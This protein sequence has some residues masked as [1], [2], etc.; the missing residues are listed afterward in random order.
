MLE[1]LNQNSG[2]LM[3]VFT[4]V[5]TLSTVVYAMLTGKLVSETRLMRRAHTEPR[6]EVVVKPR[7][8][9]VNLVSLH[10]RN[11]GLGP[12]YDIS[13][14]F[15]ADSGAAGAEKLIRDFTE[16]AFL[17]QG[18][19]YLG[20]GQ[21]AISNYSGMHEM[22]EEKIQAVLRVVVRYRNATG[23]EHEETYR[24]DFSEFRGLSRLGRPHL[25]TI[26]QSIEKIQKDLQN[27][28]SGFRKLRVDVYTEEDRTREQ[29]EWEA[30][31]KAMEPR[32]SKP[33]DDS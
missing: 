31:Q 15:D 16:T 19:R 6:V 10:V 4:A 30:A 5:V 28:A 21:E 18:M 29:Q 23:I 25:Y 12:A 20:P 1:F 32:D 14:Q 8:E 17:K 33:T 26:A 7:E 11:I 9:W 24:L 13:F 27:L 3:V 2:A 22:F